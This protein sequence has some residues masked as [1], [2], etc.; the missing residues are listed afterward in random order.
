MKDKIKKTLPNIITL[1][2]II[3][4]IIGFIFFLKDK[5]VISI[6]FYLY[7]AISD[8]LDGYL[9]RKWNVYTKF[10][11]YLD[12]ISDKFYVF[13]IATITVL[14]GNHL[15]LIVALLELIIALI[16]YLVVIKNKESHTERFGKFK[17]TAEFVLLII[18]LIMIKLR[19][20]WYIYIVLLVLT[21]YFQ[22]QCI[23]A[24]INQMNNKKQGLEI[25]YSKKNTKQK[26]KLLFSEF[27]YYL[28]NPVKIIK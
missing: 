23:N 1:S 4:L 16:N 26:I 22:I 5:I 6:I 28:L 8:A 7:G 11:G 10:G 15:I 20:L 21:V 25:D 2:R 9:A 24:Y 27:K 17:M 3:V 13:S 14:N 18:S 19:F 12:A